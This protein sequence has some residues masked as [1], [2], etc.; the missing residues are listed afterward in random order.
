MTVRR[1]LHQLDRPVPN[2]NGRRRLTLKNFMH[3]REPGFSDWQPCAPMPVQ[4]AAPSNWSAG[5]WEYDY[6]A[7]EGQLQAAIGRDLSDRVHVA[8]RDAEKI[9][10][11]VRVT[12][13]DGNTTSPYWEGRTITYP[14]IYNKAD[15]KY[16][17]GAGR[18]SKMLWLSE[19]GHPSFFRFMLAVAPGLSWEL[20]G[21]YIKVR[22]AQ[23]DIC[24][25][26]TPPVAWDR[27]TTALTPT[28]AQNIAV[29][30]EQDGTLSGNPVFKITPNPDDLATATYPVS[31]DPSVQLTGAAFIDTMLNSQQPSSNFLSA[32]IITWTTRTSPHRNTPMYHIQDWGSLPDGTYTLFE[33]NY[34]TQWVEN[35]PF[36]MDPKRFITTVNWVPSEISHLEI[37]SGVPWPGSDGGQT[38][39]VDYY[40]ED[41]SAYRASFAQPYAQFKT[42]LLPPSWVNIMK[43]GVNNGF[44]WVDPSPGSQTG[45][46]QSRSED[47]ADSQFWPYF[48]FEYSVQGPSGALVMVLK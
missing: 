18:L 14:N 41:T 33:L 7:R 26:L 39:G 28:G 1:T 6:Y 8:C 31:L 32:T 47:Y 38:A 4:S 30:I 19:P 29:T 17:V 2:G 23:G 22:N 36:V 5:P 16:T 25:E 27:S 24:L 48:D 10:E 20:S 35:S 34:Y 11:W 15:L 9:N 21:G 46:D 42:H 40:D 13:I 45:N 44:A 43:G 37:S 3:W 12:W